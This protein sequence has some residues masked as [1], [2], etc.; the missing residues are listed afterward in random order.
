MADLVFTKEQWDDPEFEYYDI[1]D[2][3]VWE[4]ESDTS[5]WEEH[6]EGVF[7]WTDGKFY[8][9]YWTT[10]L[11]ENQENT[12]FEYYMNANGGISFKEAEPYEVVEKKWRLKK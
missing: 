9:A 5:R 10:G 6:H 3:M 12:W 2:S 8:M 11:T 4:D 1:I 7:K